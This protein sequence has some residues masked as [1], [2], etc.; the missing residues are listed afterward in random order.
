MRCIGNTDLACSVLGFGTWAMRHRYGNIDDH[1]AATALNEAIDLGINLVDTAEIYGPL[2]SE[3][4]AGRALGARR[5]GA[6]QR[7]L[8]TERNGRAR[9]TLTRCRSSRSACFTR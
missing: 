3:E 8:E 7:F 5:R 6:S 1:E 9:R 4:L 2:R